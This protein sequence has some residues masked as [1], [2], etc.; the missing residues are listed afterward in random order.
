[1]QDS[2]RNWTLYPAGW[3]GVCILH[4]E[5]RIRVN[6]QI[7]DIPHRSAKNQRVQGISNNRRPV[8]LLLATTDTA[9]LVAGGLVAAWISA[10]VRPPAF[11][12]DEIGKAVPVDIS[13]AD[14]VSL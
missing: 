2:Q 10:A 7:V 12:R 13:E 9:F 3:P 5:F 4:P 8:Q 1:M 6:G 14:T 11:A